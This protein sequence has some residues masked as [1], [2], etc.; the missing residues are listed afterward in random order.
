MWKNKAFRYSLISIISVLVLGY[1]SIVITSID[2]FYP[3]TVINDVNYGFKSPAYV[4]NVI[5]ESPSNYNLDIVFRNRKEK[6]N[7]LDIAYHID[8]NT[9][10]QEI[11]AS[12]N[13]FLWFKC[14]NQEKYTIERKIQFDDSL[15]KEKVMSFSELDPENM[16]EPQNPAIVLNDDNQ[17]VAVEGDQGTLIKDPEKVYELIKNA[18]SRGEKKI[19]IEDEGFYAEPKYSLES[20][21]IQKCLRTCNNIAGLNITYYY[22]DK[23]F[24]LEPSDLFDT[25]IISDNYA[26]EVD[27]TRIKYILH[28]FSAKYDTYGKSRRFKKH[29]NKYMDID[30]ADYGWK[31]NVDEES[32]NLYDDIIHRR[33]VSRTPAFESEAYCYG[34]DG[35]DIGNFYAE[36]DIAEQHMFVYMDGRRI[37]DSDVVTGCVGAG[38]STPGGIYQIDYKQTPAV[39][40]GEDYE[41]KVTYWMPFNGGIGFHDATWRGSFGGEIYKYSGSH[42]CVNMPFS[43]AQELF[44]I[45]EE[46]MPVIVY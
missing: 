5:Y 31:I 22:A 37:L 35:D 21:R 43:K 27:K 46:G 41:S 24:S 29:T 14:F 1:F 45:V 42:G 13:P 7:G 11:K 17:V 33:N 25:V 40:R 10:L 39:L 28:K 20:K 19:V 18:V 8:Y 36:V 4:D 12:Q 9:R 30:D 26:T 6:I 34:D 23:R 15:L 44:G 16:T 3:N 32:E 38:H 2:A